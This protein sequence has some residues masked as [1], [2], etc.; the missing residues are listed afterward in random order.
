MVYDAVIIGGGPGGY[1][2]AVRIA[3]LGGKVVLVE[4][5]KLGGTC[6]SV[7]CIPT[8]S[9]YATVELLKKLRNARAMGVVADN[10]QVDFVQAL[11][12][13]NL[14]AS[15]LSKGIELL[16]KSNG[17]EVVSGVGE[18]VDVGKVKKVKV[19]ARVLEAKNVVIAAGGSS[20]ELPFAKF[21]S[22]KIISSEHVWNLSE[23]PKSLVVIGGGVE[24]V[25]FANLFNSFGCKVAI[26]EMLSE[27]VS[28]EEKEARELVAK[29]LAREGVV[30]ALG[31]RV[32]KASG[33]VVEVEGGEKFEGEKVLVVV[34]RKPSINA[35]ELEKFGVKFDKRGISVNGKCECSVKGVFAV[36]DV[37]GG[38]LAHVASVQGEVAAE[39]IMGKKSEFDAGVI[40]SVIFSSPE[41]A[42]VG[43]CAGE[44][45][46]R[47]GR[48]P[49]A[50]SGKAVCDGEKAGFVKV[51]MRN[52]L[53][54]GGVVVGAGAS[55]LVAEI[56]LAVKNEI[57]AT[58][59]ISTVHAH[60]TLPE[61]FVE[62]VRDALGEAIHL[63][64][65]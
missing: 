48:F 38:G 46:V 9:L 44:E 43:D 65:K 52:N 49:F 20:V 58:Q 5:G 2:C 30:L 17:V 16:L 14:I 60:P 54:V 28:F 13:A 8:K 25:E 10:V 55:E 36:G 24:G 29:T 53:L 57:S 21:D 51:F 61:A 63:P 34:G 6:T 42:R 26:V 1:V 41:I 31:K 7:G 32:V 3:Q 22:E 4:K 12:R 40:P 33:G 59:I 23:L 64:K 39:N 62:A 15:Q 37:A 50:A 27:L 18:L 11:K 35:R 45:G 56:A 19:G 47:V